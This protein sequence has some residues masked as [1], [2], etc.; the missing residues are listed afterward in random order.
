MKNH[1]KKI[2]LISLLASMTFAAFGCNKPTEEN[3]S[4][5][6]SNNLPQET[7]SLNDT[8]QEL[9][10]VH[11]QGLGEDATEGT[12]D[13]QKSDSS[14]DETKKSDETTASEAIPVTEVVNVTDAS[15]ETIKDES[16]NVQTETVNVTEVVNVTDASG[17]TVKD[18]SGNVQTE[19]VNVTEAPQAS[20]PAETSSTEPDS[21]ATDPPAV[22]DYTPVY[23][24]CKAYWL[25]M[26]QEGDFFFNGE[27]LVIE[28][29]VREGI[30]DGSYPITFASTDI[31]SWDVVA[32]EPEKKINGEVAV[33]TQ[34]A[35]QEDMPDSGFGL[36]INSVSAKP[37]DTVKVSVDLNNNPGFCGFVIELQYD[38]SALEIVNTY[39]GADF[40]N[41][42]HY[43]TNND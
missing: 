9:T 1:F 20:D 17:E 35:A 15:G 3:S 19:I 34:P 12:T 8:K 6:S 37:G 22:S 40:D 24:L 10:F 11:D 36:K 32:R 18:D 29:K 23:D 25:D 13:S 14:V 16:G 28:F 38:K 33:N 26:S 31:A 39:G 30:P 27:F 42:I 41:A 4:S 2:I 7:I 21:P 43:V 5:G